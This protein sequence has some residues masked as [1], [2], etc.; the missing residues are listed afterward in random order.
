VPISAS[1]VITFSE[2][3]DAS[4]LTYTAT[5]DPGS[6]LVSWG[7]SDTV[8][9]LSPA[10]WA[11]SQTYSLTVA[12]L[13]LDGL[14]LEPGPAPNPWS[15]TTEAEPLGPAPTVLA[16]NPADG[17][18]NVPIVASLV[19]TFSEP[20]D[21]DTLTY[22]A[23]PDPGGWFVSW[24]LSDTVLTLSPAG[25]AYSQTYSVTVAAQDPDGLPLEPGPAPNPWSFTTEA[26]PL[27]PAPTILATSPADGETG[28]PISASLVITFSEPMITGTLTYTVT[29]D[30]GGWLVSWGV[31]D[32][33]LTLSPASWAYSQAYSVTVAALDLDGLPLEPGLAP[34]PWSFATEPR[35]WFQVYLPVVVRISP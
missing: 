34:N 33:V 4:T 1:L 13:D 17:E 2:P 29:P 12:A 5:P 18:T 26:E 28:V 24:G 6:W 25:W 21:T 16:T 31:S 32:T 15:F 11:Y 22:T 14:P 10:V 35:A 3:M 7:V 23:T 30:P 9:T 8:L 27:G 20:M 19:I